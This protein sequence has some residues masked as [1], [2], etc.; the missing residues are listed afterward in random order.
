MGWKFFDVVLAFIQM[1]TFIWPNIPCIN[2]L[3]EALRV[4]WIIVSEVEMCMVQ[5]GRSLYLNVRRQLIIFDTL[6]HA[7][8]AGLQQ[9]ASFQAN[10]NAEHRGIARAHSL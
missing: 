3:N 10:P 5:R 2:G 8:D 6:L 1:Y 9:P 7:L 4:I